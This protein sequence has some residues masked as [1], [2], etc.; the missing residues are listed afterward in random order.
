MISKAEKSYIQAGLLATP[1]RRHDGRAPTEYRNI[2]LETGVAPLANGSVRLH[3]GRAE[4]GSGGT[5]ILAASKLEVENAEPGGPDAGRISAAVSCSPTAYPNLSSNALDDLQHDLTTVLH[6]TLSHP[7]LHPANLS[8]I[9][10]KKYWVLHLDVVVLSDAGN[11][12]DAIFMAAYAALWDTKVPR[13]RNIEYKTRRTQRDGD[14]DVDEDTASGFDTR[15]IS[16]AADFELQ[17]YWDE[18][19]VLSGRDAWPIAVTLN[20]ESTTHFLDAE[21]QEEQAS[22]LRL[23]TLYSFVS[24]KP[25]LQAIRTLGPGELKLPQINTLL[26]HSEEYASELSKSLRARLVE[27]DIRRNQKA[28]ERFSDRFSS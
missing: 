14:M 22:P 19:E 24:P 25:S 20:I 21:P 7:S 28:H 12:Y 23:L 2:A 27:E 13:T 1:P 10:G 8:I 26:Q 15:N 11:I 6:E 17:D 16:K 9:T 5:Q 3:I 4:D 18:G